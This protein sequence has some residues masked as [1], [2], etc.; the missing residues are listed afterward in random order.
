MTEAPKVAVIDN[1]KL[2]IHNWKILLNFISE[3]VLTFS[4]EKWQQFIQEPAVN[5]K[6]LAF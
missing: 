3:E 4:A 2:S 6:F 1:D 5:Q